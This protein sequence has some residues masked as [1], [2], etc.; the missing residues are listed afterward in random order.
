MQNLT[1]LY[2]LFVYF[3]PAGDFRMVASQFS[4]VNV[5]T[6]GDLSSLRWVES[7]L[8]HFH[9]SGACRELCSVYFTSLNFRD[10]ML[11]TGKL[12]PD[13]LPGDLATHDCI[14]GMEFSGRDA[15]GQRVMGILPAKVSHNNND[16]G[17]YLYSALSHIRAQSAL[18]VIM[19]AKVK[20]QVFT[21]KTSEV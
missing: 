20:R 4:Y 2:R 5:M 3:P 16:N 9:S 21:I 19:P 14:L 7:P 13:A 1:S 12:P 17:E 15:K 8:Q 6:R 11:A 10:V 18:V